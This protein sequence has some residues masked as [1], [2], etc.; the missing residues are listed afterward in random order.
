[1]SRRTYS[2]IY[3]D[4]IVY[5]TK[6]TMMDASSQN[7]ICQLQSLFLRRPTSTSTTDCDGLIRPRLSRNQAP[8][9]HLHHRPDHRPICP[10]RPT[11]NGVLSSGIHRRLLTNRSRQC[12][13]HAYLP[14]VLNSIVALTAPL[15]PALD[16]N[17]ECLPLRGTRGPFSHPRLRGLRH[18]PRVLPPITIRCGAVTSLAGYNGRAKP[19]PIVKVDSGTPSN[20]RRGVLPITSRPHAGHVRGGSSQHS[21]IGTHHPPF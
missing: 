18:L 7:A 4:I 14:L 10:S 2:G 16:P 17:S 11:S 9:C 13:V 12:Q 21:L 8:S 20:S 15:C 19:F 6:L 1:M 5:Y 3:P